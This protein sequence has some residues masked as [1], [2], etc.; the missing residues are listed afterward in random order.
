MDYPTLPTDNLYKFVALAGLAVVLISLTY[1][2]GKF[3]E[4]QLAAV[5]TRFEIT[6]LNIEKDDIKSDLEELRTERSLTLKNRLPLREQE[7]Q[8][9][10]KI[11]P[12]KTESAMEELKD[13]L[14]A[15]MVLQ[16]RQRLSS[17]KT[18]DADK[19]VAKLDTQ[20]KWLRIYGWAS[21]V[22]LLI[23]SLVALAGFRRWYIRVQA[24]NDRLLVKQLEKSD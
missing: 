4:L 1:P 3:V 19:A 20:L 21:I 13:Q 8:R 18:V 7:R 2:V 12:Q 5:E 10:N 6:K 14:S 9:L 24:P 17:I 15:I 22:G 11:E 16:E 23:G